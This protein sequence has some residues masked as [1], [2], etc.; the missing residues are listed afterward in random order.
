MMLVPE[1]ETSFQR[2]RSTWDQMETRLTGCPDFNEEMENGKCDQ[3]GFGKRVRKGNTRIYSPFTHLEM[4][5]GVG[6]GVVGIIA[7]R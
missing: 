3:T 7:G 5:Y 4:E 6:C 2:G 1:M